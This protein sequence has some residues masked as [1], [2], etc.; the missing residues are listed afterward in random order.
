MGPTS[1]WYGVFIIGKPERVVL[2]YARWKQLYLD[3]LQGTLRDDKGLSD[4]TSLSVSEVQAR[5]IGVGNTDLRGYQAQLLTRFPRKIAAL[6]VS[7]LRQFML[8]Y[9]SVPK[10]TMAELAAVVG[11]HWRA[12]WAVCRQRHPMMLCRLRLWLQ[13]TGVHLPLRIGWARRWRL[14]LRR[15]RRRRRL[16]Q[17]R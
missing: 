7:D 1:L 16:L 17:L 12:G 13:L 14:R 2:C 3:E 10:G 8:D 4:R 15:L 9:S 6:R 5:L 11:Q